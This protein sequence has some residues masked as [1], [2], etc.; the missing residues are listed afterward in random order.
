MTPHTHTR[1]HTQGGRWELSLT[2][3]YTLTHIATKL[4]G[5]VAE[6]GG[7]GGDSRAA[8]LRTAWQHMSTLTHHTHTLTH[9][10]TQT[11]T[12]EVHLC[13]TVT[14]LVSLATPPP[15]RKESSDFAVY[16]T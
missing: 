12:V 13:H 1:T 4:G 8:K 15:V 16:V 5:G 6:G 9:R 14:V 2:W 11:H 3:L 10:H 7:G